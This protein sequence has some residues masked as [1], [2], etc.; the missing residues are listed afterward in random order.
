VQEFDTNDRPTRRFQRKGLKGGM[1]RGG[2][3]EKRRR[4]KKEKTFGALS[5]RR[6][7]KQQKC[8]KL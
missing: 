3:A 7:N 2:R 4:E 6:T 5:Q 8:C 1:K